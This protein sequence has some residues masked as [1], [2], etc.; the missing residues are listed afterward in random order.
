MRGNGKIVQELESVFRG[1][2]WNVIK[3]IWGREWDALLARDVDGVLVHRMGEILDGES[4]K[5]SVESGAY[6]R[7]HFFGTDP[8]LL[9]LVGRQV[10]RRDQGAAP[11]RPRLPQAVRRV[12]GRAGASRRPD[13]HPRPDRQG[14]DAR[15]GRRGAQHHA[16][17]Q[18]AERAGA[19]HLPRPAGAAH[20]GREAQGRAVLPSRARLPG[21]PLPDRA[22][23]RPG[24]PAAAP[25]RR[26]QP[27]GTA[28]GQRLRRVRDRVGQPGSLDHDGLRA[29]AAQPH[30]RPGRRSAHRA[31]HPRRGAHLRHGPALQ[32][33]RH[34]LG[35]GAALR[36]GRLQPGALV[37]RGDRR[38][39]ARGGHHRGRLGG[40]VPGRRHGL[41]HA[42][43]SR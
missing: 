17:G 42:T 36:A 25:G 1:A 12:P 3:V 29:A 4:Q 16:P 31:H 37:P 28:R 26:Q 5:F 34:L 20:P 23:Q 35:A 13:R 2:G 6:I 15:P 18:E 38:P 10:R 8:R 30:P 39:G 14:L 43:A 21:D 11:R 9:A 41:R 7:E 24:R 19:A 27:H 33:G 40:V 22:A 32:G